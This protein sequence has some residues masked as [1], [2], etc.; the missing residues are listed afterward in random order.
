MPHQRFERVRRDLT[1]ADVESNL[2]SRASPPRA[3]SQVLSCTGTV[4]PLNE[5]LQAVLGNILPGA[6]VVSQG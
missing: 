1:D 6:N 3:Q 2:T 5:P 4:E